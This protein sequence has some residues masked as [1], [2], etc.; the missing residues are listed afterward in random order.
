M[1][2][3]VAEE[4][5]IVVGR[6]GREYVRRFWTDE[7]IIHAEVHAAFFWRMMIGTDDPDAVAEFKKHPFKTHPRAGEERRIVG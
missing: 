6:Y 3:P 1:H 7:A 2:S 5:R 4:D